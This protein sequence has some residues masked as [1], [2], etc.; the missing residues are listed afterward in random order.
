MEQPQC[1]E[2]LI[3]VAHELYGLGIF[4]LWHRQTDG[5]DVLGADT[6]FE[7]LEFDEAL[8]QTAG[9]NEKNERQG[10]LHHD[11]SRVHDVDSRSAP[12]EALVER[13]GQ[14]APRG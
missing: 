14:A 3:Q 9:A 13:T 8:D 2:Y 11:Q 10:H 4:V 12:E 1:F 7:V 6:A 5:E